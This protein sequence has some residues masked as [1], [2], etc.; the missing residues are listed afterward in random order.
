[1]VEVLRLAFYRSGKRKERNLNN[2]LYY[3]RDIMAEERSASQGKKN[4][5]GFPLLPAKVC[6]HILPLQTTRGKKKGTTRAGGAGTSG[7]VRR[8]FAKLPAV[9]AYLVA[10]AR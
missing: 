7:Q 1:M 2:S 8:I 10:A 6:I 9:S 5:E 4:G 3:R